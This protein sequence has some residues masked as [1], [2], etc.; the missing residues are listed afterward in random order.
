MVDHAEDLLAVVDECQA[1]PVVVAHSFGSNLTMLAAT[2]DPKGFAAIGLWEPPLPWVEWWPERTKAYNAR[3]DASNEPADEVEAMY[4]SLLGE[5]W[6]D[7]PPEVRSERRAE[8]PAFQVDMASEIS[9]PFEFDDVHVPA[10]I[11]YGTATS[12]EHVEGARW[13]A[14]RLPSARVR[15]SPGAGHF[16]PRTHPR[17]FAAF[18]AATTTLAGETSSKTTSSG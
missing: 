14:D 17:E 18:M 8:G 7:L 11:G 10:L 13:L 16:A 3:V 5:G 15:A 9:A 12:A 6:D 1:P 4:R 2:L